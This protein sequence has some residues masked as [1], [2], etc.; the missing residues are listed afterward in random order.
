MSTLPNGIVILCDGGCSN[1]QTAAKRKA[2]GSIATFV[3]GQ[4]KTMHYHD[5][6]TNTQQAREQ[7]RIDWGMVTNNQAEFKTVLAALGF[8]RELNHRSQPAPIV[9]LSDSAL[10]VGFADGTNKKAK[11]PEIAALASE[12]KDRLRELPNVTLQHAPRELMV[13]FLGH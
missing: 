12:L 13:E 4:R 5:P 3:N 11:V 7:V 9:I 2:Y 10:V 1:N 6:L 8:V